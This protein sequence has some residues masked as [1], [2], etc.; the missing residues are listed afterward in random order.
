MKFERHECQ[1]IDKPSEKQV[2]HQLSLLEGIN[3][4]FASLQRSDLEFIQM[5]GGGLQCCLE[6]KN[7]EGKHFRAFQKN[8]IVPWDEPCELSTPAG[9]ILL[10]PNEYFS[11][12]QVIEA[13]VTYL[14][15]QQFP[16]D[17]QWRDVTDD[18]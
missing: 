6:H 7:A 5:A 14:L 15:S 3:R 17:I 4:S 16:K 8:K 1:P 18:F 10:K 13:F 2:R 11:I 9:L 12:K